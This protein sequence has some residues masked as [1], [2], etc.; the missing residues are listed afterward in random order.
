MHIYIRLR[1]LLHILLT[2]VL[3][4][5]NQIDKNDLELINDKVTSLQ[6]S[7]EVKEKMFE[8]VLNKEIIEN[9]SEGYKLPDTA[10]FLDIKGTKVNII[11]VVDSSKS[12]LFFVFTQES[13]NVCI[14][15]AVEEIKELLKEDISKKINI[16]IIGLFDSRAQKIFKNKFETDQVR[17]YAFNDNLHIFLED[18]VDYPF[19]FVLD[20]ELTMDKVFIHDK[21]YVETTAAYL[22]NVIDQHF[23]N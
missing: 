9:R 15:V 11:E 10:S 22:E 1:I 20:K 6:K 8:F 12:V 18:I 13:C 4:S 23:Q 19:F 14:D 2:S 7:M 17:V 21:Y 5:C 16:C 3:I